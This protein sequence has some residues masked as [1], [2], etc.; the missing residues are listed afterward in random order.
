MVFDPRAVA[1]CERRAGSLADAVDDEDRGRI[2]AGRIIGRSGMREMMG[3]ELQRPTELPPQNPFGS[4]ADLIEPLQELHL[5]LAVGPPVCR[6]TPL[7]EA[8]DRTSRPRGRSRRPEAPHD[9]DKSGS[10]SREARADCTIR[11]SLACLM[12]LNRSSSQAATTSPSIINAA[13]DS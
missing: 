9:P 6:E 8:G 7:G 2:E 4:I 10:P 5:Q 13:D 3:H 1:P 12:R 11:A